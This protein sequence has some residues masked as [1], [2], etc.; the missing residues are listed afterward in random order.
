[1]INNIKAVISAGGKGTRI[2]SINSEVP[3]PMIEILGKPILQY[4]VEALKKQGIKDIII[5]VGY[6]KESIKTFFQD[7]KKFG[8]NISYIDENEPLG[9]AGALYYLKDKIKEDFLL[10]NGDTLFDIDLNKFYLAH[11]KNNSLVTIVTHPNSHPYD[12]GIIFAD[13]KKRVTK[14][15][16]KEEERLYYKNRVNAGIHFI[17]N[18]LLSRFKEVKKLDLDRDILKPL[19]NENQ[20]YIYD[21]P[22]YIMDMGTPDRFYQVID[23]IKNNTPSIRNLS[24]KQ[25]A[26]FLDRDG[27]INKYVG[28]L[29][30]IDDFELLPKVSDAINLIHKHNYLAI[31]ITNQPVI[32]RGEVTYLELENIHNKMETLL[33][34]E[35][36]YLDGIYYCP[37]HPDSGFDGEIKELKFDCN[38]RKPKTGL[39]DK[40][41]SDFNIDI[42]SSWIIGDGENDISCGLKAKCHTCYISTSNKK[43]N[44]KPEIECDSL[45]DGVN[46]IF[47]RK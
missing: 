41:V 25:K 37:H 1:M 44:V 7:G 33:G 10:L 3:K 24:N 31:V 5:T 8:V 35:S 39:I 12:S 6:L 21:T 2:S 46:K 47:K 30:N 17:S 23:D 27:T 14:W 26:I 38:C 13:D 9:T 29:R 20:L 19:I 42:S 36:A 43:I 18:K 34:K 28:F 40:A 16:T 4:E 22:E 15:L 45:F 11:K 32:A